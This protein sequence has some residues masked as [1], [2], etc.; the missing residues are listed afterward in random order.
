MPGNAASS[1]SLLKVVKGFTFSLAEL[2][3]SL[4][5]FNHLF[6][7]TMDN[8]KGVVV[9]MPF[10]NAGPRTLLTQSEVATT[11]FLRTKLELP[12]PKVLSWNASPN[13]P[14]SCEYIVMEQCSGN[15]CQSSRFPFPS[16]HGRR[17]DRRGANRPCIDQL[18]SVW[19]YIL[20]R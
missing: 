10:K 11:D 20:Q 5:G 4:G 14:V 17:R 2:R 6:S 7:L 16:Q 13:N 8:G 19:K 9:R 3:N 1:H 12:I 15:V 18:L